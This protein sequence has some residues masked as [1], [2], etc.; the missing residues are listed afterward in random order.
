M[1]AAGRVDQP[2][3]Q[4]DTRPVIVA[5]TSTWLTLVTGIGIG[6]LLGTLMTISHERGAEFRSRMLTA[7]D[8]FLQTVSALANSVAPVRWALE[9]EPRVDEEVA[10]ALRTM[11]ALYEELLPKAIRLE[12]LFGDSPTVHYAGEISDYFHNLRELVID[13][14]QGAPDAA[15]AALA[16]I[17]DEDGG[18]PAVEFGEAVRRDVKRTGFRLLRG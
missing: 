18:P 8:E 13:W 4:G 14:K 17:R 7:A 3:G 9:R 2:S 12:L 1:I 15:E 6:G 5:E 16:V 10:D 11:E